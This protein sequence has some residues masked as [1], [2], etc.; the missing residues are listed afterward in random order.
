MW[1]KL[2]EHEADHSPPTKVEVMDMC[3]CTYTMA[4]CLQGMQTD[5]YTFTLC[6]V[7][8]FYLDDA[9]HDITMTLDS[10]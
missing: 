10:E 5:N 8:G 6:Y 9:T 2:P 1:V 3:R 4:I 7:A